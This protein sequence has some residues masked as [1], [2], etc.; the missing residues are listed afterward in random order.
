M[1][2]L[3][4]WTSG[5]GAGLY[6]GVYYAMWIVPVI[7][8]T[9]VLIAAIRNKM[10]F[11]YPVRI[12]RV[13]ENGK[14][15]EL[16]KYGGYITRKGSSPFFRIKIGGKL[17]GWWKKVDLL[18][19]PD[20]RYMDEQNRIYY[21]QIDVNTFVQMRRK[22]NVEEKTI[23]DENGKKKKVLYGDNFELTPVESDVKYGAILGIHR[24]REI[25]NQ[26]Q[27]WKTIVAWG[28]LFF[29]GTILLI[30]YLVLL[31][32]KCPG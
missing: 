12:F 20:P 30:G 13:R 21:L 15:T 27:K 11:K 7:V 2:D 19:T 26:S 29:V 16:N 17:W 10:I 4:G 23:T 18:T 6:Q 24:I 9:V 25:T 22:I 3:F 31:K 5:M 28:A 1:A 32:T 8:L 14:V